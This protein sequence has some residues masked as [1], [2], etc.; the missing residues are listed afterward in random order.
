M[1]FGVTC[2]LLQVPLKPGVGGRGNLNIFL[3]PELDV[4]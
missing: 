4:Y 1:Y 3:E 2:R